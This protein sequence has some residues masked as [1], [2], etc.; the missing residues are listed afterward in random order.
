MQG[1][2][3]LLWY[4]SIVPSPSAIIDHC[5]GCLP[6]WEFG[7]S[8]SPSAM[9][10]VHNSH[11]PAL[12]IKIPYLLYLQNYTLPCQGHS[13]LPLSSYMLPQGRGAPLLNYPS[14][15]QKTFLCTSS[16]GIQPSTPNASRKL[17]T[18]VSQPSLA[19]CPCT[20]HREDHKN[21]GEQKASRPV[22]S[23]RPALLTE[24]GLSPIFPDLTM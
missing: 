7:A 5:S 17:F 8:S 13:L 11:F 21:T 18:Q 20:N 15:K 22:F 1:N 2:R 12:D 16:S 6:A 9:G 14:S 19:A 24:P 10:A 23:W 3:C 4:S